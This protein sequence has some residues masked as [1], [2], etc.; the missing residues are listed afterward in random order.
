M[1]YTD[2]ERDI[3]SFTTAE[4]LNVSNIW[5]LWLPKYLPDND[6][7]NLN[8]CSV[9]K[10][11]LELLFAIVSPIPRA[12]QYVVIALQRYLQTARGSDML[13]VMDSKAIESFYSNSYNTLEIKYGC[14]RETL[15]QLKHARAILLEEMINLDGELTIMIKNSL[16]VNSLSRI[17]KLTPLVPKTSTI[18]MKIYSKDKN[19]EYWKSIRFAIEKLEE[20]F[21]EEPNKVNLGQFLEAAVRGLIN[22]RLYVLMHLAFEAS[23]HNNKEI[24]TVSISQLLLLTDRSTIKGA[25][26][27][28]RSILSYDFIAPPNKEILDEIVLPNSHKKMKQFLSA[29]NVAPGKIGDILEIKPAPEQECFDHGYLISSGIDGKPFAIFVDEKSGR[30]HRSEATDTNIVSETG[31][32]ISLD[33]NMISPHKDFGFNDLPKNGKQALHLLNIAKRAKKWDSANVT[34]GSMLEALREDNYL[35][36]YVNTTANALSFAV[37]DN[38]MQLG[39]TNSKRLLSF[40][41]DSYRLVRAA[42]T[43]AQELD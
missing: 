29:A 7:K 6:F 39:E 18:S 2:S 35:Y 11:R 41:L 19:E 23:S 31:L 28:L 42:S 38:V 30:E 25:S 20:L 1:G 32:P 10:F 26:K 8:N 9:A 34:K 15:M 36:I 33:I 12:V 17:S 5:N 3:I 37:N 43:R 16:L 24:V 27:K 13:K 14:M 22:A 21:S 40:L 4:A